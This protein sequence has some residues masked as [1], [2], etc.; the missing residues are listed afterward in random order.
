MDLSIFKKRDY[1]SVGTPFDITTI[2]IHAGLRT[3]PKD[4][5][6]DARA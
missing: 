1:I 2:P 6:D 5:A 4:Y 3:R